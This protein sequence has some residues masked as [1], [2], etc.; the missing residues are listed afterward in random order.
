MYHSFENFLASNGVYR[1]AYEQLAAADPMLARSARTVVEMHGAEIGSISDTILAWA[2][3]HYGPE[4]IAKYV[5]RVQLLNRLQE[6]FLAAPNA[7]SIGDPTVKIQRET[8][9]LALLLSFVY[10]NHRFEI[11]QALKEFLRSIVS[12]HGRL[13]SI[14]IGTGYELHVIENALPGWKIEGYDTDDEALGHAICLLRKLSLNGNTKLGGLFPLEEVDVEL[15]RCFHAIVMCELLEHLP[16]PLKALETAREYLTADGYMFV[17]MAI[18]IA[19]EDHVFL[20]PTVSACQQQLQC[21]KLFV[22]REWQIPVIVHPSM[23]RRRTELSRGNY[24]A[25]VH[26]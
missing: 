12:P 20:Y 1:R 6:R 3:C 23:L 17:T 5:Q 8:Y 15:R 10:S 26:A 14:G 16:N 7:E 2:Q 9:D 4:F 24:C 19:Q 25:I 21:A 13:A 11:L 22:V 18:N